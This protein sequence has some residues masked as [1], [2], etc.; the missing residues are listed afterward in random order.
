[1]SAVFDAK[2]L[3]RVLAVLFAS[4]ESY[5]GHCFRFVKPKY[6]NRLDA[7]S[8]EGSRHT[9]GRFHIKGKFVIV[10]TSTSLETAEWEYFHTARSAGIDP[11][12]LLPCTAISASVVLSKVLNLADSGIRKSLKITLRE[13]RGGNWSS[14]SV[15]TL[16]QALGRLADAAGYEALLV[17]SA[18]A[19]QNLNIFRRNLRLNSVVEII[20]AGDLPV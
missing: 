9:S 17:P 10:Y 12:F 8:G 4:A 14:S 5:S 3:A 19:G 6:G 15:E 7:F 13:L 11:A 18:G 16:L 1:M 20:N 2:R